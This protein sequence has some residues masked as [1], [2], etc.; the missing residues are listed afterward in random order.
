MSDRGQYMRVYRAT[1]PEA[2]D[3]IRKDNAARRA[4]QVRLAQM[5]PAEFEVLV[6]EER[7]KRGLPPL[8]V[9]RSRRR[10]SQP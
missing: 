9:K 4:A 3:R 10:M 6:N 5:H 1:N 8:D 7:A 2:A